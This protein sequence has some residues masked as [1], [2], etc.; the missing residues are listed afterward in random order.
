MRI[1]P[2]KNIIKPFIYIAVIVIAIWV[3][4]SGN[5]FQGFSNLFKRKP[6]V[7]E[8]TAIVITQIKDIAELSTVQMYAEVVADSTVITRMGL[9]NTALSTM[10]MGIGLGTHRK[11]VIVAKGTVKAGIDL[12][13]LDS[14]SIFIKE[15]SIRVQLPSA[16]YLDVI[17]NPS[18]FDIFVETG[19]WSTNDVNLVK[20]KA[21]R[22]LI[23]KANEQK[24]IAQANTKAVN[25]IE[26]FLKNI[27]YNKVHI[28]I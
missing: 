19:S 21:Q 1:L 4:F 27:G 7:I 2:G 16:K 10:G 5:I 25:I 17:T 28:Y 6:V 20:L 26:S 18:D 14:S 22:L 8:N 9:A 3:L 12:K 13:L 23:N 24:I 11:L 15:D